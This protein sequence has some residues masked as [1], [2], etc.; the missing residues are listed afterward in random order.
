MEILEWMGLVISKRIEIVENKGIKLAESKRMEV[1]K[2][3]GMERGRLIKIMLR[4]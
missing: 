4:D 1:V 2:N 3:K